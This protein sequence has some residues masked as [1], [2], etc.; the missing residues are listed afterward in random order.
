MSD[1]EAACLLS[2]AGVGL[3]RGLE[4]HRSG[5]G[6][7]DAWRLEQRTWPTTCQGKARKIW[8]RGCLPGLPG[9]LR[10]MWPEARL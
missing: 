6:L 10:P 7:W 4:R 9:G 8:P 2:V 1:T 3:V 5:Y